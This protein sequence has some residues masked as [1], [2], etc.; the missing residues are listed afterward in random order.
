MSIVSQSV[1]KD[2]R[3]EMFIKMQKLPIKY[4]D[5]NTHGDIMSRYT[6][7]IDTLSHMIAQSI[8]QFFSSA[9]TII[10]V[11][12]S[13]VATNI[14]LTLVVMLSLAIILLVTKFITSKSGKYFMKQQQAVG[15]LNGYIEEGKGS[16]KT[17]RGICVCEIEYNL[18]FPKQ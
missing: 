14:Y 5:T 13:M 16:I 9:I 18:K 17:I 10:T 3:D 1:L 8:P 7:D 12:I 15:K 4:F 2:I 11:F 6:N